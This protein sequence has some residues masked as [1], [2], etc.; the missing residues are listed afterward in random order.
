MLRARQALTDQ[1]AVMA[2]R[3]GIGLAE[4][5][6]R[7][8]ARVAREAEAAAARGQVVVGHDA[9]TL[10]SYIKLQRGKAAGSR[11]LKWL[12]N[13]TVGLV[14]GRPYDLS[15]A[16]GAAGVFIP[17]NVAQLVDDL[18]AI[19]GYE[20]HQTPTPSPRRRRRLRVPFE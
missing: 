7:E 8:K 19:H 9:G 13:V 15:T 14:T 3:E 20:V 4:F 1:A 17:I 2:A 6:A 11:G 5:M 12:Y 18:L 10:A 16:A